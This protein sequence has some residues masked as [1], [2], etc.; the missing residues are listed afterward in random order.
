MPFKNPISKVYGFHQPTSHLV[1]MPHVESK[2]QPSDL[3]L[4]AYTCARSPLSRGFEIPMT[5]R[6]A[7]LGLGVKMQKLANTPKPKNTQ[8][9]WLC[10]S[11]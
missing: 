8:S 10:F 3:L 11:R 1:F 9:E 6:T 5:G 4:Q 7:Q 2:W